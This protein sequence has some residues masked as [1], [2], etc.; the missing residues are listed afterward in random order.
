MSEHEQGEWKSVQD[1]LATPVE[2]QKAVPTL[3]L[4]S[5]FPAEW[6]GL[7]G[8]LRE[9]LGGFLKRLQSNPYDPE[10]MANAQRHGDYYAAKIGPLVVYWTLTSS[11]Q[12]IASI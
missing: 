11:E 3:R 1:G 4:Y 8:E 6:E 10:I 9:T 12:E 5:D 7:T 2:R